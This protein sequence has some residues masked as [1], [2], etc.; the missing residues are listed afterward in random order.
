MARIQGT[1]G[2]DNR[3]GTAGADDFA[4]MDGADTARGL[5]GNDVM[6]GGAGNDTLYG[7]DGAD[8]LFGDSGA[9]QLYG[10]DGRDML[11]GGTG[12]D[13]LHGGAGADT[14][15]FDAALGWGSPSD[16]IDDFSRAEDVID[17]RGIDAN[18]NAAGDQA[19]RWL[20]GGELTGHAG[21]LTYQIVADASVWVYGDNDGDARIDFQIFLNGDRAMSANDF[22][23]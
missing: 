8:S 15:R 6:H 7:G 13:R 17:L 21:E 19:Y 22:L 16:I 11:T 14:F 4:M 20:A 23:F 5:G 10:G 2:A 1:N 3:S 18:W 9:D 12:G